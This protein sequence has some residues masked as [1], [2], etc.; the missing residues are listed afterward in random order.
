MT[1]GQRRLDRDDHDRI[2]A[3][4]DARLAEHQLLAEQAPPQP[5]ATD[6]AGRPVA[7]EPQPL[8]V[9]VPRR[10]LT[11]DDV[12]ELERRLRRKFA[13]QIHK[14]RT[15]RLDETTGKWVPVRRPRWRRWQTRLQC[16]WLWTWGRLTRWRR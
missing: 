6:P 5:Y 10:E 11:P 1:G 4:I 8:V 12:A 16:W 7:D 15:A 2:I 14:H 13:K 3:S 9:D